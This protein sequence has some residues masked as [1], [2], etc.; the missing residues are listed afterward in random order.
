MFAKLLQILLQLRV[1][2]VGAANHHQR[3]TRIADLN[4]LANAALLFPRFALFRAVH[5]LHHR[6]VDHAKD[7]LPVFNQGDIDGKLAVALDKLFGAVQ[8]VHQ[9]VAL[10]VLAYLPGRRVLFRQNRNIGRQRQQA[11]DNHLVRRNIRGRDRRI[12]LLA[13]NVHRLFSIV[14]FHDGIA[15]VPC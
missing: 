9:P 4:L 14:N 12:V 11:A 15:R 1:I 8:R 6:R 7:R 3:R 2:A 13:G 10:P 5:H